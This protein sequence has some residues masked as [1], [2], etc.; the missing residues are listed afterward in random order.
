M[1]LEHIE[2]EEGI[3]EIKRVKVYCEVIP[4]ECGYIVKDVKIEN[5]N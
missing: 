1:R 3:F 2:G 5:I 4:L